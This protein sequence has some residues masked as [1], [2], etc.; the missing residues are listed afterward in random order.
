MINEKIYLS[1]TNKNV[2]IET[3]CANKIWDKKRDAILVIPGGGYGGICDNRE[4]EPI[5]LEYAANGVNAFVLHYSV[6][7]N[8]KFP[9]P[10]IE[11]SKAMKYIREN[12]EK[13]NIDPNRIFA[14]GFSA[15]GHLCTAL[16]TMWNAKEIYDVINMDYGFNKPKG[17]IPVYPV[18]S[19]ITKGYHAGSFYNILGT[20][21]PS[22]E[23]LKKYSLETHVDKNSSPAFIVHTSDDEMVSVNSSLALAQAYADCGMKFEMHIYYTAPHGMA[24]S[25]DITSLGAAEYDKQ[26]NADWLNKSISWMKQIQ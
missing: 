23:E 8:A 5:A 1:D 7:K 22:S 6:A 12:A 3:F 25:N 20:E 26:S 2:F 13:Y 16:G 14:C 11:A 9:T 18:I 4:G 19:A 17:I 24:L 15:G 10:L 21:T